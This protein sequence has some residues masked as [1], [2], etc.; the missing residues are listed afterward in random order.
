MKI[1]VMKTK[2]LRELLNEDVS[3]TNKELKDV[4]KKLEKI[5]EKDL[6]KPFRKKFIKALK[7]L[8]SGDI[9]NMSYEK[10]YGSLYGSLGKGMD[11]LIHDEEFTDLIGELL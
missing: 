2:D 9:E 8:T 5:I 6:M 7:D 11:N 10:I 4:D 1:T 3:L